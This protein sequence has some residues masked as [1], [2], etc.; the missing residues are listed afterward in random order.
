MGSLCELTLKWRVSFSLERTN[1]KLSE[2]LHRVRVQRGRIYS[3]FRL[4]VNKF[5]P[6]LLIQNLSAVSRDS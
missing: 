3:Y 4:Q 6:L 1:Q 5:V 2:Q